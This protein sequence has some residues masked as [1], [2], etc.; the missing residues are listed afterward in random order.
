MHKTPEGYFSSA[1]IRKIFKCSRKV[2]T[3]WIKKYSEFSGPIQIG[4][5]LYWDKKKIRH[6]YFNRFSPF[7]IIRVN[8]PKG[9]NVEEQ[10]SE[11]YLRK[12]LLDRSKLKTQ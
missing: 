12:A 4:Q 10:M 7:G 6:F 2:I 8:Q 1:D 3:L 9:L 11:Q 5:Y